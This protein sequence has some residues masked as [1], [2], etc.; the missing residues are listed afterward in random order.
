RRTVRVVRFVACRRARQREWRSAPSLPVSVADSA[1][2]SSFA[3]NAF[4]LADHPFE[5]FRA[6][7]CTVDLRHAGEQAQQTV[8]RD[9]DGVGAGDEPLGESAGG[10]GE[11]HG[12]AGLLQR[13]GVAGEG[14]FPRVLGVIGCAGHF[15]TDTDGGEGTFAARVYFH[16]VKRVARFSRGDFGGI[17]GVVAELF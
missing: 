5:F 16:H 11:A 1:I 9:F 2:S 6:L 14:H 4:G 17:D 7:V 13:G 3:F 10:G 12:G 15:V 8:G